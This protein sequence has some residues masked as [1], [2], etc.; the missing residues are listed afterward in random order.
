M[1]GDARSQGSRA[2][3]RGDRPREFRGDTV[4]SRFRAGLCACDA[5]RS[6]WSPIR[7]RHR[8]PGNRTIEQSE[9]SNNRTILLD[10]F[11]R[12]IPQATCLTEAL[13]SLNDALDFAINV[14]VKDEKIVT[15]MG[16]RR[17]CPKCG[18][19]YHVEFNAPVQEGICDVCGSALYQRPDD[20]EEA[21]K[22]RLQHYN[23]ETKPL[24][25][26][27]AKK[28]LLENFDSLKGKDYTFDEVSKFLK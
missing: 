15:R 27:Y 25:D 11:P 9:Q 17:A 22:V 12:T 19:T 7:L 14:D 26:F 10:G 8:R 13:A 23:L 28:G 5:L 6:P 24:L 3:R 4:G 21:L 1:G 18:E 2:H 16:G 20:N